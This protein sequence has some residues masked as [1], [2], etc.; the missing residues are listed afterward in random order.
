MKKCRNCK[1]PFKPRFTTLEKHCHEIDCQVAKAMEYLE[2]Q[3][4]AEKKKDDEYWNNKKAE[5]NKDNGKE[6]LQKAINTLVRKIDEKFYNSCICCERP[7]KFNEPGSVHAA[8]R[9][10]VG[11]HEN[12]RWNLHNIHSATLYCNKH[13][14]EHKTGYDNGLVVRFSQEYKDLVDGLDL[15]YKVL[16]LTSVEIKEKIKITNKLIKD[17]DAFVMHDGIQ[18]R[19]M[20][21]K[22]I[23]IY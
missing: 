5:L 21:N 22:I 15:K 13:N 4:L 20:F 16:K 2:K 10:N 17:F 6:S 14:T 9:Y 3:K 1:Q 7:L 19:D 23:G 12:I 8:H 18:A 11:G